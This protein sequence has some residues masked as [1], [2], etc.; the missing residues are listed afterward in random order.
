MMK[1][2]LG[3]AVRECLG[4]AA[5]ERLNTT[6]TSLGTSLNLWPLID[7]NHS[8][9]QTMMA[10]KDTPPGHGAKSKATKQRQMHLHNVAKKF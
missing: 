1:G 8:D 4:R 7:E 9:D 6:T 2:G 3:G 10:A 5:F